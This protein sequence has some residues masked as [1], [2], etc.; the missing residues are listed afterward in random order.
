MVGPIAKYGLLAL[1]AVLIVFFLA[2]ARTVGLGPAAAEIG[3]S[4]GSFGAGISSLGQGI[5]GGISG[6]FNPAYTVLDLARQGRALIGGAPAPTPSP[7][8]MPQPGGGG[9]PKGGGGNQ[10]TPMVP[11][12]TPAPK[13]TPQQ[14]AKT[15]EQINAD[16]LRAHP[17]TSTFGA[18]TVGQFFTAPNVPTALTRTIRTTL[19][20]LLAGGHFRTASPYEDYYL[21]QLPRGV[22]TDVQRRTIETRI[23][24]R[25]RR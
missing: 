19:T 21:R 20:S 22:I 11:A 7:T 24:G 9:T 16:I 4:F 13:P 12:P 17:R 10:G 3:N 14:P 1:G 2:R 5:G 23:A 8:G 15:Q 18:G 25:G 6:L